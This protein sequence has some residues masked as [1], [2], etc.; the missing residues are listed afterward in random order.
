MTASSHVGDSASHV[1]DSA[2]PAGASAET[3][4]ERTRRAVRAE[5]S[6]AA[7]DLFDR[8]GFDNTTAEQIAAAAG[9]SRASFFRYF[10]TKEDVVLLGLEER[11]LIIRDALVARPRDEAPWRS[12]H[13]A[14]G[15]ELERTEADGGQALRLSR[16]LATTPSLRARQMEKRQTWK[17]LL[18]PEITRR[19]GLAPDD[20]TDPVATAMVA[21][22]LAC[23]D[24]ATEAWR[25]ADGQVPLA[26]LLDR[27]MCFLDK[28]T[29]NTAVTRDA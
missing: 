20:P 1:G 14:L 29:A 28:P 17:T 3:L 11:G 21:A 27:A 24:A 7:F 12:L 16:M 9:L 8:Q 4:R 19:M 15:T 25:H 13:A 2:E 5:V 10:K 6:A 18:V 26:R 22:A 23:L